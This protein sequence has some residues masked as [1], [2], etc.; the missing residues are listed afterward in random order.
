MDFEIEK[1]IHAKRACSAATWMVVQYM[2]RTKATDRE[3]TDEDKSLVV[4]KS[5]ISRQDKKISLKMSQR[6]DP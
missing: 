6:L 4:F 2:G 3:V 5:A 1:I